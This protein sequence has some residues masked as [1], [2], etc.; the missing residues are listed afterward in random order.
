MW[1]NR[2]RPFLEKGTR[3]P[4]GNHLLCNQN[5]Q[6]MSGW[7]HEGVILQTPLARCI[8]YPGIRRIIEG[9]TRRAILAPY[10]LRRVLLNLPSRP[11]DAGFPL[12][13]SALAIGCSAGRG[14]DIV[15]SLSATSLAFFSVRIRHCMMACAADTQL[16]ETVRRAS[17]KAM[18]F[19]KS[20]PV[21]S[22]VPA[23][24]PQGGIGYTNMRFCTQVLKC[25]QK[26]ADQSLMPLICLTGWY[27]AMK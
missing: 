18:I 23:I 13:L 9:D 26:D 16:S 6:D 15:V 17:M 7:R 27:K 1:R 10:L 12:K 2:R 3:V 5:R 21:S 11:F 19:C 25:I 22:A 24:A 8:P 4:L 20:S 14:W